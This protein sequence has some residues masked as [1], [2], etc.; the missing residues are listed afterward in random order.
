MI[1]GLYTVLWGKAKDLQEMNTEKDLSS[2]DCDTTN[3]VAVVIHDSKDKSRSKYDLEE[4]LLL[5]KSTNVDD[6]QNVQ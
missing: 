3:I 4:P 1:L 5:S 6:S 2:Q